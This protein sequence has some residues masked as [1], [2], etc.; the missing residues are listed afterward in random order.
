MLADSNIIYEFW[1]SVQRMRAVRR[2]T[3]MQLMQISAW[4][5]SI[6]YRLPT[7]DLHNDISSRRTANTPIG[8]G[9]F[10]PVF[11]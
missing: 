8:A 4:R 3:C 5:D 7:F 10:Q 1:K 6:A 11:D 9:D 2:H